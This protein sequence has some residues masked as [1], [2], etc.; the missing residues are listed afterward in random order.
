MTL[1]VDDRRCIHVRCVLVLLVVSIMM[2]ASRPA[3]S[4]TLL[5]SKSAAER[6]EWINTFGVNPRTDFATIRAAVDRA[7][8]LGGTVT[9]L[10]DNQDEELDNANDG[11]LADFSAGPVTGLGP[12]DVT[13]TDNSHSGSSTATIET[14]EWDFDNNGS[15]DSTDQNP[16]HTYDTAG[17]YDVSLTVTTDDDDEDTQTKIEYIAVNIPV[18]DF[19]ADVTF[20]SAGD[21]VTFTD[22]SYPA[23]TVTGWEWDFGDPASGVDNTSDLQNPTHQY[24]DAGVYTVS[25]TI[26]TSL[27]PDTE[28]RVEYIGVDDRPIWQPRPPVVFH[29]SLDLSRDPL[30]A[31]GASLDLT[32]R[33]RRK[34]DEFPVHEQSEIGTVVISPSSTGPAVSIPFS[35]VSD[36]YTLSVALDGF[37]VR[38]TGEGLLAEDD[39]TA[40]VVNAC[41]FE[42]AEDAAAA[43]GVV[44][45]NESTGTLINSVV[46]NWQDSGVLVEVSGTDEDE[47]PTTVDIFNSTVYDNAGDG[48]NIDVDSGESADVRIEGV[49]VYRNGGYG[50]NCSEDVTVEPD[51]NCVY[52]NGGDD[53]SDVEE[54]NYN[55]CAPGSNSLVT[56]QDPE[57]DL[58]DYHLTTVLSPCV[59]AGTDQNIPQFSPYRSLDI[60]NGARPGG[61]LALYDI[62]ADERD[63]GAAGQVSILSVTPDPAGPGDRIDIELISGA[64]GV[65]NAVDLR[66]DRDISIRIPCGID[67]IVSWDTYSL[68]RT[69]VPINVDTFNGWWT[70]HAYRGLPRVELPIASCMRFVII[71]TQPPDISFSVSDH[72][73]NIN[74]NNLI[75]GVGLIDGVNTL[76]ATGYT[77]PFRSPLPNVAGANVPF[78]P[79]PLPPELPVEGRY[80]FNTGAMGILPDHHGPD[81]WVQLSGTATDLPRVIDGADGSA[82]FAMNP[83]VAPRSG[84]GVIRQ[85]ESGTSP[86]SFRNLKIINSIPAP[87]AS[88]CGDLYVQTIDWTLEFVPAREG[89]YNVRIVAEDRAGNV[90]NPMIFPLRFIWDK[91]PPKTEITNGCITELKAKQATFDYQLADEAGGRFALTLERYASD[92]QYR[93]PT[94]GSTEPIAPFYWDPDPA[95]PAGE[96]ALGTDTFY[97]LEPG[98]TYRFG[99]LAIDKAGNV[100]TTF[101]TEPP[102]NLCVFNVVERGEPIDT[103]ITDRP[104]AVVDAV[105]DPGQPRV[106]PTI[107]ISFR[108]IPLVA[109]VQ[110]EYELERD[111]GVPVA[112]GALGTSG[113]G[114]YPLPANV[115]SGILALNR[116]VTCTFRVRAFQ[117]SDGSGAWDSG[118]PRDP[119]PATCSFVIRPRAVPRGPG[120]QPQPGLEDEVFT[121]PTPG[122]PFKYYREEPD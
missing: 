114:T 10:V 35:A 55:G 96:P 30:A 81:L 77:P 23:A 6:I 21:T 74:V 47:L 22:L 67:P 1:L 110:F 105:Y 58:P 19:D 65:V 40:V 17:L 13:F 37:V 73:D 119:T 4:Q 34:G 101:R 57:L 97:N 24:D 5:V 39:A 92:D 15:I 53:E 109:A 64:G 50:I 27:G 61:I 71:D 25:L 107:G 44:F 12:L 115:V 52:G 85:H 104:P 66:L 80:W 59:D 116:P 26:T 45:R 68:W 14:W 28:T 93:N 91:T 16:T 118:E 103:V 117:D 106:P 87:P 2:A 33:A 63:A 18:A 76:L 102:L 89:V 9:I 75:N 98:R 8:E 121:D 83:P 94:G 7:F 51:F 90:S 38:S 62:G 20:I 49:I 69:T 54:D 82:G 100:D 84:K 112:S 32:I 111:E 42:P 41:L 46:R 113:F 31:L 48:I 56:L 95:S 3:F 79:W 120:D 78:E 36:D 11:P 108:A 86:Q 88:D 70:I 29:E 72:N 60:D 43:S 99:V 122:Q